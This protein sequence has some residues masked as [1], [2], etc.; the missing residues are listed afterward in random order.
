MKE[1]RLV[2]ILIALGRDYE[3]FETF[4]HHIAC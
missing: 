1:V 2:M 3:R 4:K